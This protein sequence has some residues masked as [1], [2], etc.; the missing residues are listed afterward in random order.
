ME[1][2]RFHMT[3]HVWACVA[4]INTCACIAAERKEGNHDCFGHL[5]FRECMNN[6]DCFQNTPCLPITI[7]YIPP[8]GR[9]LGAMDLLL[10]AW[11]LGWSVVG[12][13]GSLVVAAVIALAILALLVNL[14]LGCSWRR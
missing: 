3:V 12:L 7:T 9:N 8:W 11:F 10:V 6:N 14:S 5:S 1:R 13:L 2:P 4:G